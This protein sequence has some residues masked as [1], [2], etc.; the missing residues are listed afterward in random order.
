MISREEYVDNELR[1][2]RGEEPIQS[3]DPPLST[4]SSI[5]SDLVAKVITK[6]M[7]DKKVPGL[8]KGISSFY[9]SADL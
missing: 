4:K 5:E 8:W 9:I 6:S 1:K 7:E 3:V 2:R